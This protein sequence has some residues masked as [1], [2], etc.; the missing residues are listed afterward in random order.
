MPLLKSTITKCLILTPDFARCVTI[1]NKSHCVKRC[2]TEQNNRC[3]GPGLYKVNT[4]YIY[5]F[6]S[7]FI[8]WSVL[9]LFILAQTFSTGVA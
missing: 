6:I 2:L 8:F 5:F 4:Q 3:K 1:L 7:N 9:E